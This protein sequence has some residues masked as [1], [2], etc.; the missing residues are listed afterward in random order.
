MGDMVISLVLEKFGCLPQDTGYS[1]APVLVTVF[2][3]NSLP[4]SLQ[5]A[6]SLRQSGLKVACY[7]EPIK[8]GKQFKYADRMGMK[9]AIIIGPDEQVKN[10][11]AVKD[12]RT[13]QQE[14][15]PFDQATKT[16]QQMLA[17]SQSS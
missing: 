10:L 12:L 3:E 16:I 5:M 1:P 6:A 8:I 7:P 17:R 2:D 11:A 14:T 15:V 13:G 9:I 4:V